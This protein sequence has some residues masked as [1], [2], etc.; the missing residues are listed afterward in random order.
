MLLGRWTRSTNLQYQTLTHPTT[1]PLSSLDP[2]NHTSAG[3]NL[4][5]TRLAASHGAKCII[6]DLRLTP[7]ASAY[8]A[9]APNVIF[10]KCDVTQWAD[11]QNLITVSKEK[12]GDVPDIYVPGA[13]VFEPVLN[14]P[15]PLSSSIPGSQCSDCP[16]RDGDLVFVMIGLTSVAP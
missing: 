3:I 16:P 4:A 2:T 8:I 14:P 12:F 15:F 6:A 5:F 11:L 13:G 7:E 10:T 9:T 1:T